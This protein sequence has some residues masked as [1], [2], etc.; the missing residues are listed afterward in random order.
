MTKK[1]IDLRDC[2]T[3]EQLIK[4]AT[5]M[6]LLKQ[7]Y[8]VDDFPDDYKAELASRCDT[9]HQ[10]CLDAAVKLGLADGVSLLI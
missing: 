7:R 4:L 2:F 6:D 5:S 10:A 1:R 3:Y 8:M 9:L